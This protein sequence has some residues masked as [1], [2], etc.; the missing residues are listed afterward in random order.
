MTVST[1]R[2]CAVRAWGYASGE[3]SFPDTVRGPKITAFRHNLLYPESSQRVTV[4]G[5]MIA[6]WAGRDMTMKEAAKEMTPTVY[7]AIEKD[8]ARIARAEG[9]SCPAVQAS[10][11]VYRKRTRGILFS[12]QRELFSGAGRWDEP[13]RPEDYPPFNAPDWRAWSAKKC[14]ASA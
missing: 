6:L 1:Y 12:T 4:D 5:H 14:Q 8:V 11:W 2:A 13:C 9:L 10:L 3:V 7:R